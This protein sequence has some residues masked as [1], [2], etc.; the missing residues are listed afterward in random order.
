MVMSGITFLNTIDKVTVH[1]IDWDYTECVTYSTNYH[2]KK[3]CNL[4]S[5]NYAWG[6]GEGGILT[7]FVHH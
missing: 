7:K 2:I 3:S 5:R 1:K 4:G 6:R